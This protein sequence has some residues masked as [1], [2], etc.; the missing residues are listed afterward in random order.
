MKV[1]FIGCG[2]FAQGNHNPAMYIRAF[3]DLNQHYLDELATKYNPDYVTSDMEKIFQD[4][5]IEMV[6]C[7]TKPDFRLP[8]M[9]M[10]VEKNKPL[11]VE[12]PLCY[13]ETD[14][15]PMVR[16]IKN[17]KIPFAVGFNR[18]YCPLMRDIK[19]VF[20]KCR[21]GNTSI[22]YRIVGEA[23][24]WP[25]HHFDSV[26]V[27]KESTIIHEVTHIFDLIN[28]LTNS[29][30]DSVYT[31]G[32]GNTDN[33]ITLKYPDDL[34]AVIIAGDN[35]CAG[36]PKERIEINTNYHTIVGNCFTQ[37]RHYTENG[38]ELDKNYEYSVGNEKR[39]K[40]YHQC[41]KERS[42]WRASLTREQIEYG[43]Y[44]D[45]M[46]KPDKGHYHEI[47]HFRQVITGE[48][49]LETGIVNGAAANIIAGKAIESWKDGKVVEF[50]LNYLHDL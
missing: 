25:K 32:G 31:A 34:T 15:E 37:L 16:L 24:L 45:K 11:F 48:K 38:I 50:D 44:Y 49:K 10:A 23:R 17:S 22:I 9:K 42:E 29:L 2:G 28:W 1:G 20:E 3:C 13:S 14:I 12:K 4:P 27:N 26:I 6:I 40:D 47:E 46:P 43:Y 19:P 21:K 7:G 36:F 18:P 8:V 41:I 33:I 35:S 5:E 39:I 30:P